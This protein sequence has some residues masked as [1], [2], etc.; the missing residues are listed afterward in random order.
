MPYALL[1]P[2]LD[3]TWGNISFLQICWFLTH[4]RSLNFLC[5]R[6]CWSPL[7]NVAR[8]NFHQYH[9][10]V[11]KF[12]IL[13]SCH[14]NKETLHLFLDKALNLLPKFTSVNQKTQ[15]LVVFESNWMSVSFGEYAALMFPTKPQ[16]IRLLVFG[17]GEVE[18]SNKIDGAVHQQESI[19]LERLVITHIAKPW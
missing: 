4:M 1:S 7:T 2:H 8:V 13:K 11:F 19:C 5:N 3:K 14:K 16:S 15:Y 17:K 18:K 9:A 6:L 10:K 12:L